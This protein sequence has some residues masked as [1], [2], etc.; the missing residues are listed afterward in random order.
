KEGNLRMLPGKFGQF[1]AC[2]RYPEC[3]T[4]FSLPRGAK[5]KPNLEKMCPT[6]QH[7]TVLVIRKGKPPQEVCI[8]PA[9]ASKQT[10]PEGKKIEGENAV[11]EKCGKGTM[12]L[13]KSMYGQFLGCSEYPKCKTIKKI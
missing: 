5:I 8:N 10:A 11:C 4:T 9:C 3:K 7:P 1:I 13:R 12:L 6:C 2:S